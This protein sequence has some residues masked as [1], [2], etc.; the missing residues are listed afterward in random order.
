MAVPRERSEP[1]PW[2]PAA[3]GALIGLLLASTASLAWLSHPWFDATPDAGLYVATARSIAAGEGYTYL[4]EPFT[5][6]PPGFSLLLAPVVAVFGVDFR[7]LN[8]LVGACGA[9]AIALLFAFYRARLGTMLAG[10][11]A[12]TLWWNPEVRRLSGQVM[13]EVPGAAAMF[14]CLLLDRRVRH[15]PTLGRELG[16]GVAIGAASLLRS[17]HVLLLPAAWLARALARRDEQRAP[18]DGRPGRVARGAAIAVGAALCLAPWAVRNALAE[19]DLASEQLH[20]DSYWTALWHEDASDPSSRRLTTA[21]LATRARELVALQLPWL[22]SRMRDA[23]GWG[24]T[25]LG[26]FALASVVVVFWRRR[27]T[28]EAFALG[29][30]AVLAAYFAFRG[31]LMLP[32][33]LIALPA[34][35]EVL[36]LLLERVPALGAAR[37]RGLVAAAVL[38]LGLADARPQEDWPAIEGAH[39]DREFVARRVAAQLAPDDAL[40]AYNGPIFAAYLDRPVATLRF[41]RVREGFEGVERYVAEHGIDLVLLDLRIPGCARLHE[42]LVG[43][44]GEAGRHGAVR[45]VRVPEGAQRSPP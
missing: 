18:D 33:L 20:L 27:S 17:V 8:L 14:A 9:L 35:A 7:A 4:G 32:V 16:L 37:A 25:A 28:A 19:S 11:L 42:E 3:K 34:A 43:R 5:V 12:L 1:Q 13:S 45:W 39:R 10:A 6:R 40:A 24:D 15:R 29:A 36:V 26:V 30:A 41:V 31:R 22:G 23:S 21:E 2:D 44:W 38:A